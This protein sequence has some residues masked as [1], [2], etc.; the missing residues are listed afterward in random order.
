LVWLTFVCCV[1]A[2]GGFLFGL[3][4]IIISGTIGAIKSGFLLTSSQEGFFV[5]ASLIGCAVGA[6]AAGPLADRFGRKPILQAAGA[7][8]LA[9]VSACTL[10][11]SF[12][13][14]ALTRLLGGVGV[15][16]A[17]MTC[18]LFIAEVA[19]KH[20]RGRLV[21]L[22]QLAITIGILT[23]LLYNAS[24]VAH[25][26]GGSWIGRRIA[27]ALHD[28]TWRL[29]FAV[30]IPAAAIFILLCSCLPESPRWLMGR[31]RIE[32]AMR[33]LKALVGGNEAAIALQAF[34]EDEQFLA[35]NSTRLRDRVYRRP[36]LVSIMLA[37]FSEFSGVT[38]IFYYGPLLL[39]AAGASE[40]GALSGFALLGIVNMLSTFGALL[41]IDRIGRR[42]LLLIGSVGCA[43]CLIALGTLMLID[44][45]RPAVLVAFVCTFIIIYAAT[46]GPTKFVVAAEIFP[47]AVRGRGAALA[48]TAVWLSGAV[49]NQLFPSVRDQFGAY[50]MFY[51]F[52]LM[53]VAQIGFVLARVSETAGRSLEE[54]EART[55]IAAVVP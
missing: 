7:I 31:H 13:M 29:M 22:Y 14:L 41:L 43:L 34:S 46:L 2:L 51:F 18:P 45:H 17:S 16:L 30:Q 6:F 33:I 44:L 20:I 42:Q 50:V 11:D 37:I 19:P 10:A 1:S 35:L 8:T 4:S 36:L 25:L 3:D 39:L 28:D 27:H 54:I 9:G 40:T 55:G 53:L 49:I 5:S 48:T 52:A 38:V 47:H 12:A 15:G 24:I 23:A 26:T 32:D 21:S